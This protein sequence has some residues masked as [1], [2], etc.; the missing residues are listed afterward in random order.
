MQLWRHCIGIGILED[1][2]LNKKVAIFLRVHAGPFRFMVGG[3][4]E[5]QGETGFIVGQLSGAQSYIAL[6]IAN[7]CHNRH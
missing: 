5:I 3:L 7:I 1:E 6:F 4:M 2:Q